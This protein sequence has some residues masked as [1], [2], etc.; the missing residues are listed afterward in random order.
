MKPLKAVKA[1][2][3]SSKLVLSNDTLN[4]LLRKWRRKRGAEGRPV[5]TWVLNEAECVSLRAVCE[6]LLSE[7][8]AFSWDTARDQ[9][10]QYLHPIDLYI[11]ISCDPELQPLFEHIYLSTLL[12]GPRQRRHRTSPSSF[13]AASMQ[14]RDNRFL[15]GS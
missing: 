13:H 12:D 10:R 14:C 6:N 8:L 1:V 9:N 4:A 7:V 3:N 15:K 11:S 2:A 5:S